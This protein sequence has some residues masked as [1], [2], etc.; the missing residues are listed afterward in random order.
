VS[1]KAPDRAVTY[2][3]AKLAVA[4]LARGGK[5]P[6]RWR[7]ITRPDIRFFSKGQLRSLVGGPAPGSLWLS[8][9]PGV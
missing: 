9:G 6:K 4:M 2:S 1:E 8:G 5:K 7:A 3:A